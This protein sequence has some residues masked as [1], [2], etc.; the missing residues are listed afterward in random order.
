MN[1]TMAAFA[2][3]IL[4]LVSLPVYAGGS[5]ANATASF[6]ANGA[7][8]ATGYASTNSS[9]GYYGGYGGCGCR[10]SV[11]YAGSYATETSY[12]RTSNAYG[13]ASGVALGGGPNGYTNVTANS[14]STASF[15]TVSNDNSLS[16]SASGNGAAAY[17]FT[18]SSSTAP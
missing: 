18:N 17:G 7:Q 11:A 8:S 15:G 16:I 14:S 10:A 4:T 13:S 6:H 3:A 2:A 5:T 12:G 9:A 1:I